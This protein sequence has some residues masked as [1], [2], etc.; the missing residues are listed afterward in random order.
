[1]LRSAR[2][3]RS[4]EA[5]WTRLPGFESWLSQTW[6]DWQTRGRTQPHRVSRSWMHRRTAR[7]QSSC[8]TIERHQGMQRGSQ[9]RDPAFNKGRSARSSNPTI[10]K[11]GAARARAHR[12]RFAASAPTRRSASAARRSTATQQGPERLAACRDWQHAENSTG[13]PR[14]CGLG[15]ARVRALQAR[16]GQCGS[17]LTPTMCRPGS[18]LLR[19]ERARTRQ[20]A[21]KR[22]PAWRRSPARGR[23]RASHRGVSCINCRAA[24]NRRRPNLAF[25]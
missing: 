2:N 24:R 9:C 14:T 19:P 25:G 10:R 6:I 8:S 4:G 12:T 5:R 23:N 1:M 16:T 17:R 22:P 18:S 11:P 7:I 15:P 21:P 13:N 3:W 20:S